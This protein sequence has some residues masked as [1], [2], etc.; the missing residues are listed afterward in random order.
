VYLINIDKNI[1]RTTLNS[2]LL[3]PQSRRSSLTTG[4][5][6]KKRSPPQKS[7]SFA[8]LSISS[9]VIYIDFKKI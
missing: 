5:T 8:G 4:A 7:Y 9:I 3:R 2:A 1:R 6:Q